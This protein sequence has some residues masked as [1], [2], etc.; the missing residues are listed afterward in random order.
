MD[1]GGIMARWFASVLTVNGFACVLMAMT[2]C[3]AKAPEASEPPPTASL[4]PQPTLNSSAWTNPTYAPVPQATPYAP[5]P[6]D[7]QMDLMRR[8][9]EN[10]QKQ[11]QTA[12]L[13][14]FLSCTLQ[15][16]GGKGGLDGILGCG[17]RALQTSLSASMMP[18]GYGG[19]SFMS[20]GGGM[21]SGGY[22]T[23][24]TGG[25]MTGGYSGGYS[26][27]YMSGGYSSG[28]MTGGYSGGYTSGYTGGYTSR[29][30]TTTYG[31]TTTS[32]MTT[33]GTTGGF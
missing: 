7:T 6:Y 8:Q 16:G 32:G 1:I 24:Y 5:N 25:Y 23:G 33:Y 10:A 22:S 26:T 19:Y 13:L 29:G 20:T 14:S 11:A 28:Y 17:G 12:G 21:T 9:Q 31:M 15:S 27:G 4:W 18:G 2:A 30:M 3:Q